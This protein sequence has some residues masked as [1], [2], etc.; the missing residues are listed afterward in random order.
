MK[1]E[2]IFYQVKVS[3]RTCGNNGRSLL[4]LKKI[5]NFSFLLLFLQLSAQTKKRFTTVTSG[6]A[7]S[8][9]GRIQKRLRR[10]KGDEIFS[11]LQRLHH[12]AT[13]IDMANGLVLPVKISTNRTHHVMFTVEKHPHSLGVLFERSDFYS[14]RFFSRTV[15]FWKNIPDRRLL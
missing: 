13:A 8:G 14:Q 15:S 1:H 7:L 2:L 4:F 12:Y 3:I 9:F 11:T 6:Q 5:P 10:P